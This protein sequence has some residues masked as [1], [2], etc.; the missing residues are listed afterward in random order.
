MKLDLFYLPTSNLP[1][2]LALYL[3]HLGFTELW[4]ENDE[5]VGLASPDGTVSIMIDTDADASAGP[6]LS[7][8]RVAD[9]HSNLPDGLEVVLAP[10]EIPGGHFAT[11]R[12]A[13]GATLYVIDQSTDEV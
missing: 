10:V 7:V 1:A 5:N 11:Y 6:M 2:T 12:D 13:G 9:F 8:D 4:N 3:D